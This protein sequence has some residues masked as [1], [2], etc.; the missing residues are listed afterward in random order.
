[1]GRDREVREVEGSLVLGLDGLLWL[2][3]SLGCQAVV[4][5]LYITI[6][7]YYICQNM[8]IH[9]QTSDMSIL[10]SVNRP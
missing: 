8:A 2:Y 4:S 6:I 7:T 10:S 3:A 1:M 9:A 5:G